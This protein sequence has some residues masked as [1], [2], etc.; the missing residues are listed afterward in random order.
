[1]CTI[2]SRQ[3]TRNERLMI[4]NNSCITKRL[5]TNPL[6]AAILTGAKAPTTVYTPSIRHN[7]EL[8][9]FSLNAKI[10]LQ[11]STTFIANSQAMKDV[12]VH[13]IV[14]QL[15]RS[16]R[17]DGR[18]N[19]IREPVNRISHKPYGEWVRGREKKP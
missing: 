11:P 10:V 7:Q 17:R 13:F 18:E 9:G 12:F 14:I 16:R 4:I 6:R 2:F 15:K 5:P 1:M 8:Q 3:K 19:C